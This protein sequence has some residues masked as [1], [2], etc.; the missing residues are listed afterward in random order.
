MDGERSFCLSSQHAP[1]CI[2][3]VGQE[4]RMAATCHLWLAT[5]TMSRGL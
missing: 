3:W 2:V 1:Q 4:R 5:L